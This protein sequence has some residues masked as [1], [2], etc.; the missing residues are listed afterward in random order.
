MT[1]H[2]LSLYK[3]GPTN[4]DTLSQKFRSHLS[5]I[6]FALVHNLQDHVIA[7]TW[8]LKHLHFALL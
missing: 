3:V 1:K 5:D 8:M 4:I 7:L 2:L 6:W